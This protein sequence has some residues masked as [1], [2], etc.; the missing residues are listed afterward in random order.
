M[1]QQSA[2]KVLHH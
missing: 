2:D 1:S